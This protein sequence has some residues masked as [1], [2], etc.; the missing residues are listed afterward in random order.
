[1]PTALA[2]S[3]SGGALPTQQ[4]A[5][6]SQTQHSDSLSSLTISQTDTENAVAP[7]ALGLSTEPSLREPF[8]NTRAPADAAGASTHPSMTW[9][10]AGEI[11]SKH[12]LYAASGFLPFAT[13][14]GLVTANNVAHFAKEFIQQHGQAGY[15]ALNALLTMA[16]S[17]LKV[18][19]ALSLAGMVLAYPLGRFVVAP[20]AK[21]LM[22]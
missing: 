15:D 21:K 18:G 10:K 20:A 14:T 13:A 5:P 1:M 9:H 19:A 3:A 17:T 16:G 6:I 2:Q 22:T 4:R 8:G 11:I 7:S 12:A